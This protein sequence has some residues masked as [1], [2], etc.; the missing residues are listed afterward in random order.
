MRLPKSEAALHTLLKDAFDRGR[1]KRG[2]LAAFSHDED[3]ADRDSWC[4]PWWIADALGPVRLDPCSNERSHIIAWERWYLDRG[5]D[6]LK[7]ARG[8]PK[9][10]GGLIYVNPPYSRGLVMKFV[11]AFADKRSCF[12]LRFDTSTT[13]FN[14]MYARTELLLIPRIRVNFE[15][16]PGTSLT[17]NHN[18]PYPHALMFTRA[19]DANEELRSLCFEMRTK[20]HA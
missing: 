8:V 19:R 13:W 1:K 11:R 15:P 14:E 7:L 18:N 16:P 6:A 2:K 4:T 20:L 5:Q 10:P 12:L 9:D 17:G 3:D